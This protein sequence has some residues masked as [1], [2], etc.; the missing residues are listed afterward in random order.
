M[1]HPWSR[2]EPAEL[3][4][5][6]LQLHWAAQVAA[7][8]GATLAEPRA[9]FAHLSLGPAETPGLL[10]G[11]AIPG[12]R[13]WRAALR[14]S[15]PRLELLDA[16]GESVETLDLAGRS[17]DEARAWLQAAAE[18]WTGAALARD[19]ALPE[20]APP[21]HAVSRGAPFDD[22]GER[23]EQL[24]AW[25]A[26]AAR[27][28]DGVRG[29]EPGASPA[30]LW[31]HHLDLAVLVDAASEPGMP[32]DASVGVGLSPGDEGRDAPYLYVTPWPHPEPRGLP[33]L[34]AGGRWNTDG[35]VGAV[36]EA[37]A[38]LDAA[39]GE[40][41]ARAEQFVSAAMADARALLRR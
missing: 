22:L 39:P 37:D 24:D 30:R 40:R 36:L 13:P 21:E 11:A 17:L 15:P 35:W 14:L 28:L 23:A 29:R 26:G 7:A 32:A 12:P 25:F 2:L 8:P 31:P 10:A 6:R 5:A 41:G 27:L 18:R 3:A 4:D 9:D 19:L 20:Q 38:V 16:A 34:P 33:G 1:G